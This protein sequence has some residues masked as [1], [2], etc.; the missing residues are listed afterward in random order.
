MSLPS[1]LLHKVNKKSNTALGG[2]FCKQRWLQDKYKIINSIWYRKVASSQACR[3]LRTVKSQGDCVGWN[4]HISLSHMDASG[5]NDVRKFVHKLLF[6]T[7]LKVAM[8]DNT[9]GSV[10]A[11]VGPN[12]HRDVQKR[13]DIFQFLF[14]IFITQLYHEVT[15]TLF[16]DSMGLRAQNSYQFPIDLE[17]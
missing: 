2:I 3:R 6:R 11:L 12:S 9:L 17:K 10:E 1:P 15:T 13:R 5:V 4:P 8:F 16:G 14:P 7:I